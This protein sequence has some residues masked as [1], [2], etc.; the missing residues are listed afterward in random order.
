MMPVQRSAATLCAAIRRFDPEASRLTAGC[1]LVGG[2]VRD[3]ALGLE[4]H[5]LDIG[6][7]D[8][9]A[10]ARRF[11][12]QTKGRLVDL[13]RE[14]FTTFRVVVRGRA[15]DF[16]ELLDGDL[17]ADL[18]RRDFT[19]NAVGLRA[20][21]PRIEDPFGGLDDLDSRTLRMVH[22]ANLL[23]DPLRLLRGVRLAAAFALDLDRATR[24][25]IARHAR[26][27]ADVAPERVTQEMRKLLEL[28][29]R[30]RAADLLH[31]SGLDAHLLGT[32]IP[33]GL[34]SRLERL[35]SSDPRVAWAVLLGGWGRDSIAELAARWKWSH[36][37]RD[38]VASLRV[39]VEDFERS[40]DVERN[41]ILLH[42]A[43]LEISEAS[44]AVLRAEGHDDQAERI[45][46]LLRERADRLFDLDPLLDGN[47]IGVLTRIPPGPRIGQL[48]RGLVEAQIR[49]EVR[50]R[51]E[52]V[53]WIHAQL[54]TKASDR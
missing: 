17:R 14:R 37:D 5:D 52:A 35:H 53:Q 3:L 7:L 27:M 10:E 6:C 47:E 44:V 31:S 9:P 42:D 20:I 2:T 51:E 30:A 33:P 19:I 22:E 38:F 24:D 29:A 18:G 43:G 11:A 54:E 4:P 41:A 39:L 23:D 50:S 1:W 15:W 46:R 49:G 45:E 25:A 21:E 32:P 8:A 12:R 13:G 16:S 36:N 28:P 40:S 26:Q 34:S 48:R